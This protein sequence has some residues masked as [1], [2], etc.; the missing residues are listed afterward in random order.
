LEAV[1]ARLNESRTEKTKEFGNIERQIAN[2]DG[3]IKDLSSVGEPDKAKI[4]RLKRKKNVVKNALAAAKSELDTANQRVEE[5]ERALVAAKADVGAY[6][7]L[8]ATIEG[9]VGTPAI[10]ADTTLAT[11]IAAVK[12]ALTAKLSS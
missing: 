7:G 10:A 1:L 2:L 3:K 5:L 6:A 9:L 4:E 11:R 8:L 12:A